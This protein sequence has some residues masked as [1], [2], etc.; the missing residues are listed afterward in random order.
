MRILRHAGKRLDRSHIV[1]VKSHHT[2]DIEIIGTFKRIIGFSNVFRH[3][4]IID[5][6]I[7]S[8]R[9]ALGRC[10]PKSFKAVA[11][12]IVKL[13]KS[14]ILNRIRMHIRV[15]VCIAAVEN[16][17]GGVVLHPDGDFKV[18]HFFDEGF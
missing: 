11:I 14:K 3:Q 18:I 1:L 16:L 9:I 13:D 10:I 7:V 6:N 5:I 12:H 17:L 4:F 2:N 8:N 15:F